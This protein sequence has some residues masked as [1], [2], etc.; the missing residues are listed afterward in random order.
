MAKIV[1]IVESPAKAKTI[2]KFL[3]HDYTVLASMGHVRDLPEKELGFDPNNE[4]LP[5]YQV[6]KEKRKIIQAIKKE[7]SQDTIIYLATDEDREGESISWHLI[8]A[9]K[10]HEH[11]LQ[12]IV[13]HEITKSA[14]VTAIKNPRDVDRKLVDAQQARRILDRTVGYKLSPLLW[15]KVKS[16][17]SAG[18]V[19]SVALRIVVDREREIRKFVPE[20]Y[21][22]IKTDFEDFQFQAELAKIAGKKAKVPNEA[23][24]KKIADS[25]RY[26]QICVQ[27]IEEKEVSR[28][29][30]SPFT[31][32][33][34]QQESSIKLG[35]SVKRTMIVAQQLYEGNFEIPEYTGGLITYMRTDS[36][37]LSN[38]CLKQAQSMIIQEFGPEYALKTPRRFKT[39]AKGAQEAHEAIRPVDFEQKPSLVQKHL[40]KEQYRLYDLIWKRTLATQMAEARFARTTLRLEAGRDNEYL[41]EAKGQRLLFPRFSQSLYRRFRESRGRTGQQ[42]CDSTQVTSE[43]TISLEKGTYRAAF[44]QTTR[45]LYR[46]VL[47]QETG[48]GRHWQTFY[49]CTDHF[50]YSRPPILGKG[51][52]SSI[53]SNRYRRS[54]NRFLDNS[55][56]R[57][58][59]FG[60]YG[61]N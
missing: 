57:D 52:R 40:N 10:I 61:A 19:Q 31:T 8:E 22:K 35:Y 6:T 37:T 29:P 28:K 17:L 58:R 5:T 39:K 11:S 24:A 20:E 42:R 56:C 53:A 50:H 13:F 36:V 41:L 59:E 25:I 48:I 16:G 43:T 4:F 44:H 30:V 60:I 47:S 26:G 15:K 12:R 51:G 14:I 18:R 46:S 3:G 55:F 9:L 38:Q 45:S 1:I 27:E 2:K 23:E 21:W 7:I 32:S 54:G 49:L 33:T 34:L